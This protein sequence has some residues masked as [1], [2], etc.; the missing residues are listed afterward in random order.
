MNLPYLLASLP[1]LMFDAP[2]P[3]T[4]EAFLTTCREHLSKHDA[5]AVEALV[6][7]T[8]LRPVAAGDRPEV[9]P[10][11]V[12]EWVKFEKQLRDA[13][14]QWRITRRK[15]TTREQDAPA[16]FTWEQ[17]APATFTREQDAPATLEI[18]ATLDPLARD[19]ALDRLRWKKAEEMEGLDPMSLDALFAY[20]VKLRISLRRS[21]MTP[22]AGGTVLEQMANAPLPGGTDDPEN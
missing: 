3:L 18:L 1:Y 14:A 4:P 6:G 2:A 13:V 8:G 20:A 17:D 7:G 22:E 21:A 10:A 5:K 16:T 15:V 12:R 19:T 11:F 9:C